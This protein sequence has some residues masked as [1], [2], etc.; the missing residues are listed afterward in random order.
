MNAT[1]MPAE[2]VN[3]DCRRTVPLASELTVGASKELG[4]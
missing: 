4:R 1:S 3:V 2:L